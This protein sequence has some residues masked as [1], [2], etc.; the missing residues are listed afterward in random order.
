MTSKTE[1][2]F[3]KT[4]EQ[5]RQQVE[6]QLQ[7]FYEAWQ[8]LNGPEIRKLFSEDERLLLWGTDR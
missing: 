1:S 8:V 3:P 2:S 4:S 5:A 7:A 6:A